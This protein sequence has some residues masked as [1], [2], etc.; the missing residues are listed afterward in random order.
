ME[1]ARDGAGSLLLIG[2]EAGVGKTRLVEEATVEA[3]RLGLR[4]LTGHCVDQQGAPPYLPTIEHI[5]EAARQ[6]SPEALRQALGENAPEIAK[7]MP[8][9]RLR[10]PDIPEPVS[11]PPEQERRYLLHGVAE[12]VERAARA[13]PL[14]LVFEDLHWADESTLLLLRHLAQR[15]A[16]IPVLALGTYR[17]TD[18]KPGSPLGAALPELLRQRLAEEIRLGPLGEAGVASLL[19]GRAGSAPPAKLVAL[20]YAE[21][22]GNPFF[23]EEVFRH[24][25]EAGKLL[26]EAGRWRSGSADRRHR[27]AA[28]R[29][30]R[31][32]SAARA[33]ERRLPPR[34]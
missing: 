8:E 23:V 33:R 10:Y 22:E 6:V 26:D 25:H 16:Q 32:R 30:P 27:R 13:T 21:T 20:V 28:Q 1:R 18:L 7:L 14:V 34:S 29:E 5:E 24:L 2:G 17:D 15:L 11:L 4:V 31:H 9:L 19:A 12:F 3:R